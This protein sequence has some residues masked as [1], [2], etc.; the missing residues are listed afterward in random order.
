MI[1][2]FLLKKEKLLTPELA[3]LILKLSI[4]PCLKFNYLSHIVSRNA[5]SLSLKNTSEKMD[6]IIVAHYFDRLFPRHPEINFR[7]GLRLVLV[8][9]QR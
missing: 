4:F 8:I 3:T 6:G 2:V 7:F 1:A 9:N 5:I